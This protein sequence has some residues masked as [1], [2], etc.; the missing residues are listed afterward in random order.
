MR[1]DEN[2]GVCGVGLLAG[3][4]PMW[5]TCPDL[6][7]HCPEVPWAPSGKQLSSG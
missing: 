1:G 7:T 6:R 2:D 3:Q 5:L 4:R